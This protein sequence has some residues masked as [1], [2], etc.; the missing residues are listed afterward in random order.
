[1]PGVHTFYDGSRL[2][3]PLV[4]LI[5]FDTDKLNLVFCQLLAFPIA[6]LYRRF[7]PPE[8]QNR[9]IRLLT[10]GLIGVLFCFFC[11]GWATKHIFGLVGVSYALLHLAPARQVNRVVFAFAM[12][13]LVFIHWYR[14][15]VLTNYYIDVT[16][17][18]MIMVQ[19]VTVLAFSLHDGRVRRKE[20]LN[21][22]QRREALSE[23]PPLLD[24]LSYIFQFQT[25]LTGPLCFYTDYI[26][27]IE[28]KHL[29]HPGKK[30]A[31]PPSPFW[32]AVH[33]IML[34]IGCLILILRYGNSTDPELIISTESLAMPLLRWL[35][36]FWFVIFMQRV[37]YYY[38]WT[39]ADALCNVSGFGFSGYAEDGTPKW[40]L[41][42]NVDVWKVEM[43]LSFKET[44][45]GWNIMT[46]YW[47][48]RIAYDRV[49]KNYRTAATYLLSAVWHGFFLGYYLTFL[50][51]ALIT[52]GA[53]TVRRCVRHRFQASLWLSRFYDVITFLATK[54]ALMYATFPFV[55]MHIA[56]GLVLYRHLYF[57]V[58]IFSLLAILV[59]PRLLPPPPRPKSQEKR[60][61]G[62]G[63]GN[64][65]Q[66]QKSAFSS[67]KSE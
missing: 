30:G 1:M 50:T 11:F 29:N 61:G 45:D 23:I 37:Q 52:V 35:F 49:P 31:A 36:L 55:T 47:L 57:S 6:W 40:D 51:G 43:A 60:N 48:R 20:E 13:Y 15:Y 53:R 54:W 59:L 16:G 3:D 17:P 27:F 62:G 14:W 9:T 2:L 63:G 26:E 39:L 7:L 41:A 65:P 19:K 21:D 5:G 32:P 10:S 4:P 33:K 66:C 46:M 12:G 58:H 42:T 34:S 28:G 44:L 18:L 38:A 22:I 25:V 67:E 24:Y 64:E 56:P 8:R